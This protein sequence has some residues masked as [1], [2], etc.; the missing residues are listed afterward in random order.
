VGAKFYTLGLL[1]R[2]T[3]MIYRIFICKPCVLTERSYII[4][5]TFKA[6]YVHGTLEKLGGGNW[7]NCLR[8]FIRR[9]F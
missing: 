5:Q 4:L 6:V 8:I 3:E 7:S 9:V 1:A 2:A